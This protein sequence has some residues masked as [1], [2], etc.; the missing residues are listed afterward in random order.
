[1]ERNVKLVGDS[2]PKEEI[3]PRD[4]NYYRRTVVA[5]VFGAKGEAR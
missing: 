2:F 4:P 5:W 3:G 1:M